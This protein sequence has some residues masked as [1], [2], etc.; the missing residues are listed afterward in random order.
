VPEREQHRKRGLPGRLLLLRS[1]EMTQTELIRKHLLKH[2]SIT[3]LEAL[4]KYR[5]MRLAARIRDLRADGFSVMTVRIRRGDRSF[6]K[7]VMG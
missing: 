1:I 2:N 6:G 3:P 5:C 7:Y 4:R